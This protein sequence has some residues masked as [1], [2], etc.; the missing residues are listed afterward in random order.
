MKDS[1]G[2]KIDHLRLSVTTRCNLDCFYCHKEGNKAPA[3][4]SICDAKTIVTDASK[5][6]IRELKITGGEPMLWTALP[7][8]IEHA[9]KSG[10]EE[11]GLTTNGTSLEKKAALL[12][13]SGLS[14]INIGCDS[15]GKSMPK[16]LPSLEPHIMKAKESGLDVK[17]N[18]V[19]LD[20][21]NADIPRMIDFCHHSCINLQLIELID[22][23]SPHFFSLQ[24][25]ETHLKSAAKALLTRKMQGRKRYHIGEI[26][27][28]LVRPD[29]HFCEKCNKIRV[30]A[31]G[32]IIPCLR[33]EE[34][35]AFK[36]IGSFGDA[37]SMRVGYGYG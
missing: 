12:R 1:L 35:L 22:R 17:I 31:D 6:G 33:K 18:M 29:R 7:E 16:N 24:D 10:Y 21:N 13:K 27:I 23:T 3:E 4:M 8:L 36:G 32:N 25:T 34:R 14:H 5:A 11:I 28:E 37:C 30:G 26:F 19:A 9:E 20:S 2:R 15:V